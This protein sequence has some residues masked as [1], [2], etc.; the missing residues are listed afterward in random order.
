[1]FKAFEK[2]SQ[3]KDFK[4]LIA[5]SIE[6]ALKGFPVTELQASRL[7]KHQSSMKKHNTK[8]PI[9]VKEGGWK[10]G[11][12]LI[13]TDLAATLQRIH[14]HGEAGFYEGPVAD[15]IVAEMKAGKGIISHQD[16]K[17]YDAVWRKPMEGK[18]KDYSIISMPP[19]SSGGIAL[20]Q[21][22]EMVEPYPLKSWGF[23][24]TATVHLMTEAERRVYADRAIH[25][26]DADF[27]PV[28]KESLL[29]PDYLKERMKSF[30]ESHATSSD[31]VVAGIF[32][33]PKESEQTTHFSIVDHQGNA[34]SVTTTINS[35]FGSK[36]VVAGAGF[37]LNNE[38]D[39]F[40][41]KPGVPNFYGLIGAEANAI[42][43]GKR[44]LSSMTPTIVEK[45]N[46][47]FMVVGTPGG[48]TIITSVF[49]TIL[50]AIEFDMTASQAVNAKRFH[51]Q[52]KPDTLQ[53]EE[54]TFSKEQLE[55]LKNLGHEFK[56]RDKIGRVEAIIRNE[57][58]SLD[59]AADIRGDDHAEGW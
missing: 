48:S 8:M 36:T 56:S 33:T 40:S 15:K 42:E 35:G 6:L 39:D 9:F 2:Y 45:N 21:L 10:K 32:N 30:D 12:L 50:N 34:V 59:A 49:Q 46:E 20:L 17:D 31:S 19:P 23:Q 24:S 52:W 5:P 44:M 4:Q 25:L 11:D 7:N 18:Y 13:Q 54:G 43:P 38:M 14:D 58:C 3:L 55:A 26:A 47:L 27:Y 57:D 41:A 22:L 16:L 1:M 29:N 51:H 28:P 37:L 53:F